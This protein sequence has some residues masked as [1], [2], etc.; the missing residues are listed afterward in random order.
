MS[1]APACACGDYDLQRHWSQQGTNRQGEERWP[2]AATVT[3]A[4]AEKRGHAAKFKVFFKMGSAATEAPR[5]HNHN[6]IRSSDAAQLMI[7]K[8]RTTP[9]TLLPD[10]FST[11]LSKMCQPNMIR[12]DSWTGCAGPNPQELLQRAH[13]LSTSCA[14][15]YSN[16]IE[17]QHY[18]LLMRHF[19]GKISKAA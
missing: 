16:A 14:D 10:V 9:P 4:S 11:E 2:T 19:I 18:F 6:S 5:E 3:R 13:I 15:Q 8:Q 12:A 7:T 1:C 17:K